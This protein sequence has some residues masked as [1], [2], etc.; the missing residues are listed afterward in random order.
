MSFISLTNTFPFLCISATFEHKNQPTSID[1]NGVRLCFQGFI[2]EDMTNRFTIK[3]Q[4]IVSE[5]IFNEIKRSHRK[6]A[7][8]A[9]LRHETNYLN[10][11]SS[12]QTFPLI[13]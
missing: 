5:P 4:P 2:K 12:S 9:C 8:A 3:L 10:G 6:K 11:T 13:F 7:K 1:I